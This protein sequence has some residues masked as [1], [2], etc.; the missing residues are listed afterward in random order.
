MPVTLD[1]GIHTD[2]IQRR[3][4]ETG[5]RRTCKRTLNDYQIRPVLSTESPFRV[6]ADL[7]IA[8]AGPDI[9]RCCLLVL[10][11]EVSSQTWANMG[12]L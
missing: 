2:N 4:P 11:P 5:V 12:D 6:H 9:A 1:L 10:S 3:V 7:V 8:T